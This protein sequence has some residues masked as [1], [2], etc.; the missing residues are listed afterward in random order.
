MKSN[1]G[2]LGSRATRK[3]ATKP[4]KLRVET[5]ENRDVPSAFL[6]LSG[7]QEA[8]PAQF[9]QQWNDSESTD[10][11]GNTACGIPVGPP[12]SSNKTV[13]PMAV[14]AAPFPLSQTFNLH[15]VPG[16]TKVIYLDFDGNT[17]LGTQWNTTYAAGLNNPIVTPAFN[18]EGSSSTFSA[19]EQ[20]RIQLIWQRVAEDYAPFNVDVTTE[21]P[22]VEALRNTGGGDTHWGK[23]VCIGGSY[24][25]WYGTSA[26]GVAYLNTFAANTD[27]PCFVFAQSQ[28]NDEKN[29]A[30]AVS[31]E[32]GHT[33]GLSHDG[34]SSQS[35]YA[36]QQGT[37]SPG[38]APIMGVGY[39]QPV[40]QWSKGQYPDANNQEDDLAIIANA[41][42]GVGYKQDD[43][44][45]SIIEAT[46]LAAV[47]STVSF[48]G[49][50]ERT[51]DVDVFS[52]NTGV[53]NVSFNADPFLYAPDLDIQME[54]IDSSGNV[55]ALNNPTTKST[56]SMSAAI[57]NFTIPSAG[58]Y[59]IRISGVGAGNL[60]TG[61][62]D[63]GSLGQYT[64][65]GS[66]VTTPSLNDLETTPV[67]YLEDQGPVTLTDTATV[68]DDDFISSATVTL[69]GAQPEDVLQFTDQN[70]I[71]GFYDSG[72]G[73]LSLSGDDTLANYQA[74]IRS[75]TY[76][77]LL[78][79][80]V[81][82][83]RTV[84]FQLTDSSNNL[85]PVVTRTLN[86]VPVNDPPTLDPIN[87]L[88]INEGAGLQ[89][90]FLTGISAGGEPGQTLSVTATSSDTTLIPNPAVT[91]TSPGVGGSISFTPVAKAFGSAIITV[92][93]T[94]NGGT[95]DGGTDTFSQQFM[96]TVNPVNDAPTFTLAP[97]VYAAKNAPAQTVP[98]FATNI[99]V[100]PPNESDQTIAF[101]VTADNTTLFTPAG[102][103]AIS[104][105]GTLTFTPAADATGLATVTVYAQDDGT[106]MFGGVDTSSSKTF[107]L[108]L[109][110]NRAPKLDPLASPLLFPVASGTTTP[111]PT[112]VGVFGVVGASDADPGDVLGGIAV[113]GVD[114]TKGQ[115]SYSIN[116]T[117][118]LPLA[119]SPSAA[120]LL[121]PQ[122]LVR[123]LPT[124]PG[125]VGSASLTYHAWDQTTGAVGN[126]VD[127]TA[128]NSTGLTTAFSTTTL[129]ATVRIAPVV[130]T[131]LEDTASTGVLLS[132]LSGNITDPD[133]LAA[134]RGIAVIGAGGS[135]A[136][137]WE[138]LVSGAW[139]PFAAFGPTTAT[140][141]RSTD[142][143][144]FVAD[145]NQS[146]EAFLTFRA[147]DQSSGTAGTTV[148]LSNPASV[149]GSSPFSVKTDSM[150]IR[151]TP[152]NDRPVL[153]VA[154]TAAL[155]TTAQT[156]NDPVGDLVST[157]LGATV[158]D[159][160]P[161][162]V[163]GIAITA[164]GK[165]GGTWQYQLA[166]GGG[167]QPLLPVS[168][169]KAFLLGP[170]DRLRFQPDGFFL[171]RT[172]ISYKAWDQSS[173][174]TAGGTANSSLTTAFSTSVKTAT[175]DV[176][177]S[178]PSLPANHAPVL[179][180]LPATLTPVLEDSKPSGDQLV[181]PLSNG[182][183]TD[184]DDPAALRGIA[185]T[186]VTG[187]STGV[188]QYA[189]NGSTV[190]KPF[191]AVSP[192][193][194]L[195]LRET[196]RIRYLPNLNFNGTATV[197]Y[198][199]WDQTRGTPGQYANPSL[200]ENTGGS[201][202]F[203]T[204][205]VT[206]TVNVT[207]VN[208]PP[209]LNTTPTP[210]L[211]ALTP[212]TANSAGDLVSKLLG[213]ALTDVDANSLQGIAVTAAPS[214]KG[215][216][217]YQLNS[218]GPWINITNV[219]AAKALTLRDIDR[220][221]FVPAAGFT[222]TQTLSYRGWDQTFGVPGNVIDTAG[223]TSISAATETAS[224]T[225][226]TANSRPVLNITPVV[227]LPSLAVNDKTSAGTVISAMLG[228]SVTDADAGTVPGIA[229]VF[230]DNKNGVWQ[231]SV[232]NGPWF[233]IGTVKVTDAVLLKGS[234]K[235]RFVP[236][237]G[238][239]GPTTIQYKAW[240]LSD[241]TPAG[242][243]STAGS[244]AFSTAI[245][246]ATLAVNNAPVLIV[247]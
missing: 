106:T 136:G 165:T 33:F 50:I 173:G 34:T 6:P 140:L 118:W 39:Y 191:G 80:P 200:P 53:G 7:P 68:S 119:G 44:G 222:G 171:G 117:V 51:T 208:D 76:V 56:A 137:H 15:S 170:T 110:V 148:D 189:A 92:T 162:T 13:G 206:A 166:S 174:G 101:T 42:N 123:F 237:T 226:T 85:S 167:W 54:L 102:Q 202:P 61:Y 245:E 213:T 159:P 60:A 132:V 79:N 122:T 9:V 26:G 111:Q 94:D 112:P 133:G 234:D 186:G 145:A 172:T 46:P 205:T 236:N 59:Y 147:W 141:L 96:V 23:R 150:F 120:L 62:S 3:H 83:S 161:G 160:D 30:E 247:P 71:S 180:G 223:N 130:A 190:W 244:T 78:D 47:G 239:V 235:I 105:D 89:T 134:K 204:A 20:T 215:N 139:K 187:A 14:A 233:A 178:V 243:A 57:T 217:Q 129:A 220:V 73:I 38:W 69:V 93:F 169:T 29:I 128:P 144:R 109:G 149:G 153:D 241:G 103:P 185:V 225:V 196:D 55:L 28:S 164:Y 175:L 193:N 87:D 11:S 131:V 40:T 52:F 5:L 77:N 212:G 176:V 37:N 116:G 107:L 31:H 184:P 70:A 156:D 108:Y 21:D 127:L 228:T 242:N 240:D 22:G 146:G 214:T 82:G 74:A 121:T 84:D 1:R 209:V 238:Y 32:V 155:T 124:T 49:I 227:T 224:I 67:T 195:L 100:G 41:T 2:S 8:A 97:E 65:T 45:D 90:V 16:A 157:I 27:T 113:T 197:T 177:D 24:Q 198:R 154:A 194:A 19:N 86:I 63:Y 17:T 4:P 203:S 181:V 229:V 25:D 143:V 138:F 81:A 43:A 91:Y 221:R 152:V 48:N 216:W 125:F 158:T 201:A 188:W 142:R 207:P 232:N 88:T 168:V 219:S 18:F 135:V 246:T 199:G 58:T 35:Y 163:P 75:V 10:A 183:L 151:V 126:V 72:T 99:S 104:P 66:I 230:A 98:S 95:A 210:T 211:T 192:E 182:A 12:P 218:A 64:L 114:S 231:A 36:G 115:W 179:N